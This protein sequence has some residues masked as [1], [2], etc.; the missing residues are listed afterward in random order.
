[1]RLSL[2]I[3]ATLL[4]CSLQTKASQTNKSKIENQTS[5]FFLKAQTAYDEGRYVDAVTIYKQLEAD[6]IENIELHYNLANAAFKSGDLPTAIWHYRKAFYSTPRDPDIRANLHFALNAAGA[7]EPAGRFIQRFLSTLS[8]N[9]WIAVAVGGYLLLA[10]L[11]ILAQLVP[12]TRRALSKAALLPGA[13]ILLSGG[14]G[15]HWSGLAANPEWVV[16]QTGATALFGP[17]EGSTAHYKVPRGALVR[18]T[19]TDPKGWIEVK[20]DGKT[21]WLKQEYIRQISP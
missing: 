16:T 8:R 4:T 10:T 7:T 20:Y 2:L 12:P 21:G 3:L 5:E 18:Q 19:A 9:E 13:L 15:L 14:G 11:L 17:V 1:M 6:G